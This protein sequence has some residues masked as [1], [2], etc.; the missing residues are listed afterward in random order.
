MTPAP[1][2]T[3]DP[4]SAPIDGRW[5][6]VR[7]GAFVLIAAQIAVLGHVIAGGTPPDLPLLVVMSGLLVA[8]LRSVAT[9]RQRFPIL[10]AA[11]A[12]TQLAFHLV[13]TLADAHHGSPGHDD[14][15]RMLAFHALAA[16]VSAGL[17]AHGDRMLFALMGW[18]ARRRPRPRIVDP[19]VSTAGWTALV[20]RAGGVL[21]SR[22]AGSTVSRRGPPA[23][24]APSC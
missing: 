7:A 5:R 17:L 3:L 9:R 14:P 19:V 12:G 20:D 21:R 16:V 2:D 24:F 23:E 15:V 4:V 6:S 18:L 11:M 8:A 22:L 1:G 10:L 13:L